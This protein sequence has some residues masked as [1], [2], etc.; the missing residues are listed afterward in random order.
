MAACVIVTTSFEETVRLAVYVE[1]VVVDVVKSFVLIWN[2]RVGVETFAVLLF[3][4][5]VFLD[6]LATVFFVETENLA[7][8]G[9]KIVV[10]VVVVCVLSRNYCVDVVDF[11]TLPDIFAVIVFLG[12]LG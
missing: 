6:E 11:E 10:A 1:K 7:V 4:E 9:V 2:C 8:Y 12:E 3:L 5:I